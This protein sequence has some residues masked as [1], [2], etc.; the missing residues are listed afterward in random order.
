MPSITNAMVLTV[1]A[2]MRKLEHGTNFDWNSDNFSSATL[3][4]QICKK[5][6]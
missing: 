6:L 2:M 5:M 3:A 1:E 4:R